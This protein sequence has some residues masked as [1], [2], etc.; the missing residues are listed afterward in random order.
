VKTHA[1]KLVVTRGKE[2]SQ[3]KI[4][5]DVGVRVYIEADGEVGTTS[6]ET[7]RVGKGSLLDF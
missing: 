4:S 5:T 2:V 3:D 1:L 7:S 6:A